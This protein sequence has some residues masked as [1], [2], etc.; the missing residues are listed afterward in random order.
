MNQVAEPGVAEH[1]VAEHRVKVAGGSIYYSTQGSGPALLIMGGG[2]SNADTLEPLA[3][4]LAQDFTVVTYDRR[5]YSRSQVD[6]PGESVGIEGH[7]SDARRLIADLGA[8]PVAV[9]GTSFGALVAL[10]LAA[11]DPAAVGPLVVH[12]PPLGQ[13]LAGD[14]REPF[15]LDLDSEKDAGAALNA[16][17]ASVGVSRGRALGGSGAGPVP[18][19]VELF[20]RRDA[21]AIGDYRLDLDRLRP[22]AGRII[23]TASEDSRG[24][25]PYECAVRLAR[26]F[27]TPLVELPGNHAGMIQ[28]PIQFALQ[29]RSLLHQPASRAA[30]DAEVTEE[31]TK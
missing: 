24:F 2:P 29:L 20:I 30:G 4:R 5:G 18:A 23:V 16:I 3:S 17:A 9:F 22:M 12:E 25:Y 19:D 31:V 28:H 21:P 6:D 13:M 15:D 11:S 26:H 7:S 10:D 14:E 1:R 27:G 8:G